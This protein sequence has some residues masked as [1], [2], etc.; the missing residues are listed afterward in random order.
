MWYCHHELCYTSPSTFFFSLCTVRQFEALASLS[1]CSR[2]KCFC[3]GC[4]ITF[5]DPRS[6]IKV[7]WYTFCPEICGHF[8][9]W[10]ANFNLAVRSSAESDLFF[11]NWKQRYFFSWR[12]LLTV[13]REIFDSRT[14]F[15]YARHLF[16][17]IKNFGGKASLLKRWTN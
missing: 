7:E 8:W 3:M 4:W 16:R 9:H 2:T 12:Y 13:R 6:T 15:W 5:V 14:V 17:K 1:R 11:L 10:S